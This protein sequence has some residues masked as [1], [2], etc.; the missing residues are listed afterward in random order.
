MPI[1][2]NLPV[3]I[4]A[5]T[6]PALEIYAKTVLVSRTDTTAFD[7]FYWPK[8]TV[9]AGV[10]VMGQ[11][12]SDAVTS[13]VIN[14]GTNPGTTNE[15][16]AAFDVKAATGKGYQPAGAFAGTQVGVVNAGQA[17]NTADVKIQAKYTESGGA[18]T[19]GG[20]WLVKIEYYYPQ[21][22]TTY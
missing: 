10:Y 3:G 7:A 5:I 16:L 12:Q 1:R 21:Q 14:L 17:G 22:G 15:V 9:I 13:A 8:G 11:T 20:P 6:P 2:P 4:T 18:S 19:T